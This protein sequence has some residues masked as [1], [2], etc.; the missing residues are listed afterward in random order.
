MHRYHLDG[1]RHSLNYG[2]NKVRFPHPRPVGSKVRM[3]AT[4]RSVKSQG[5]DSAQVV[6][7]QRFEAEGLDK[8]VCVAEAIAY[9]TEY[10]KDHE[11]SA[12]S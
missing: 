1:F 12:A 4:I 8:P 11:P 2:Y 9:F 7:V 6:I 3:R 5:E 10:P